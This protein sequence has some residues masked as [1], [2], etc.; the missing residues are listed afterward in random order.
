VFL[1]V[2]RHTD[3]PRAAVHAD[4]NTAAR[5]PDKSGGERR[6]TTPRLPSGNPNHSHPLS[7]GSKLRVVTERL[8]ERLRFGQARVASTLVDGELRQLF[9]S[10]LGVV[11]IIASK[12]RRAARLVRVA[13][14]TTLLVVGGEV[15]CKALC[16]RLAITAI[17]QCVLLDQLC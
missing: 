4:D 9:V 1:G 14:P 12:R 15:P 11:A 10:S 6:E 2:T 3:K 5:S 8:A 17:T 13:P 16:F 7:L